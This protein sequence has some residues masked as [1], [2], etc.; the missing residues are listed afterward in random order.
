MSQDYN[1]IDLDKVGNIADWPG[2]VDVECCWTCA[3]WSR[4]WVSKSSAKKDHWAKR[5][6]CS[7]TGELTTKN[8]PGHVNTCNTWLLRKTPLVVLKRSRSGDLV[9]D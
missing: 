1:P 9:N 6:R 8:H 4:E 7:V 5:G 2:M 3:N